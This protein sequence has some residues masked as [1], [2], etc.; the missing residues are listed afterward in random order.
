MLP[1]DPEDPWSFYSQAK[2]DAGAIENV[3]EDARNH[4]VINV[5]ESLDS[6]P[7]VTICCLQGACDDIGAPS[8]GCCSTSDPEQMNEPISVPVGTEISFKATG[9][10]GQYAGAV[11]HIAYMINDSEEPTTWSDYTKEENRCHPRGSQGILVSPDMNAYYVWVRDDYCEF[12]ST[13]F[14]YIVINGVTK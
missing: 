10:P 6:H 14:A 7:F 13:A 5:D 8:L 3:F 12:G 9:F 11:T 1:N 4:I 2:D